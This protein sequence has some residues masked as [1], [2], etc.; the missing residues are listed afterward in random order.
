MHD[1]IACNKRSVKKVAFAGFKKALIGK[2]FSSVKREGKYLIIYLRS[3]DKKVVMHFG[4]TGF[5]V[6]TKDKEEEVR[7]SKV[8]FLFAD[9][10]VLHWCDIRKFGAIWLVK[11]LDEIKGLEKIGPDP[12]AISKKDFLALLAQSK[13]KNI[14]SFLM[15]QSII[16]GIGNEYSDE[17]LF[18]SKINPHHS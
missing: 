6:Y 14:K 10:S 15:D 5:L 1:V 16:A 8:T 2:K 4:L 3:S 17:I 11:Q 9:G 12:L 13:K 18:Q 7:F